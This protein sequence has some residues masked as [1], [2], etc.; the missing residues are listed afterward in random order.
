MA[1]I[2]KICE[3]SNDNCAYHGGDMWKFK[4]NHLQINPECRSKY[5]G[6]E[7]KV[8][9]LNPN[10]T[11]NDRYDA[12]SQWGTSYGSLYKSNDVWYDGV[13]YN[14]EQFKMI[15]KPY[16]RYFL[17][18]V[19]KVFKTEVMVIVGDEVFYNDVWDM[20][21]FKLNMLKMFGKNK[22]SYKRVNK[23]YCKQFK[24]SYNVFKS[25]VNNDKSNKGFDKMVNYVT[26]SISENEMNKMYLEFN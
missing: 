13:L 25:I 11:A 5:F 18:S 23:N 26:S 1:A 15:R 16:K 24:N 9:F 20:R 12:Y 6:K 3:C 21:K 2:E 22:V 4:H 7:A 8:F 14:E 10:D 17:T 19:R